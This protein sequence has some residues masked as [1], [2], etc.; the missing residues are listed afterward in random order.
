L[1]YGTDGKFHPKLIRDDYTVGDLPTIDEDVMLEEPTFNRKSWIDTLNEMKVQY[2]EIIDVGREKPFGALYGWGDNSGN[3]A[4]DRGKFGIDTGLGNPNPLQVDGETVVSHSAGGNFSARILSSGVLQTTGENGYGQLGLGDT[5]D[6]LNFTSVDENIW[7]KV[8]CGYDVLL[9]LRPDGVLYG[10]GHNYYGQLGL[11]D[12]N[13]RTSLT[14]IMNGVSDISIHSDHAMIIKTDTSLWM[15]GKNANHQLGLDTDTTDRHVFVSGDGAAISY[16]I[17]WTCIAA[18]GFHSFGIKSGVLWVTGLNWN[19]QLGLA[20]ANADVFTQVSS[21][22]ENIAT[23]YDTTI[24]VK[25]DGS[26]WGTGAYFSGQLGLGGTGTRNTFVQIGSDTDWERAEP[27]IFHSLAIKTGNTLWSCGDNSSGE[28]GLGDYDQRT[29]FTQIPGA[30][31]DFSCSFLSG[32]FSLGL[33][34][35]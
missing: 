11:G 15:A 26:M 19:G 7:Q 4:H 6:R 35:I 20:G 12:T 18:G 8:C 25:T 27:S 21:G 9:A 2:S 31:K 23:S 29:I 14:F 13:V 32:V 28:L 3:A 5:V 30:W 22:W 1:R 16:G 10:T 17:G 24:G 34:K 33:K